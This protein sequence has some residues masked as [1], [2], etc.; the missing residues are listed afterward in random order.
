MEEKELN[1]SK[2]VDHWTTSSDED[3]ST[4]A[5]LFENNRYSW[6]LFIG[7]LVIE[8][9]LKALFVK[10]N[11]SHPPLIH[12]LL[13]LAEKAEMDLNDEQK[14]FLITVTAFNI[15]GRYDDYKMTFQK[16]CTPEFSSFWIEKIKTHR[17]WIKELIL[18]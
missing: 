9:L 4:M 7:H 1:I 15:N 17:I 18:K 10:V 3:F 2:L 8:K 11:R 13:R 5:V 14:V 6:S 16:Q 12:N